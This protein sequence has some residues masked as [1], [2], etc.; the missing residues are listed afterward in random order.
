MQLRYLA[1]D[2]N[3][4]L[5]RVQT[6]GKVVKCDFDDILANLLRIIRVVRE[7]LHVCDEHEH[8]VEVSFVLKE[9]TVAEGPD[10]VSQMEFTG[11]AVAC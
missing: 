5:F 11:R 6:A 9:N 8:A 1:L 2:K 3:G 4:Y 7:G 10:I